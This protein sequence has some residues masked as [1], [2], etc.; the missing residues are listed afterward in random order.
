MLLFSFL[1]VVLSCQKDNNIDPIGAEIEPT[2]E[3]LLK[4]GFTMNNII[5][6]GKYYVVEGDMVFQ[7]KPS[8]NN[9]RAKLNQL[10]L[11]EGLFP[12][13]DLIDDIRVYVES[14]PNT[15]WENKVIDATNDAID[16][17]NSIP[18]CKINFVYT[19]NSN[20]A[21]ITVFYDSSLPSTTWAETSTPPGCYV[22]PEL[23]LNS[24]TEG[25]SADQLHFLLTHELGH[26]IGFM[27]TDGQQNDSPTFQIPETPTSDS[28]SVMNSGTGQSSPPSWSVDFPNGFSTGDEDGAN[29]LYPNTIFI[30]AKN[31][32]DGTSNTV[33][34]TWPPSFACAPNVI[35]TIRDGITVVKNSGSITHRG[36]H[37]FTAT[38]LQS[39][40][41]YK[42]T[43]S[44]ASNPSVKIERSNAIILF[45]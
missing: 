8:I 16:E 44:D 18:N 23:R 4:R 39:N 22:G 10:A 31:S 3:S 15:T 36:F 2:L 19:T 14:F 34:I 5:D 27:H 25:F 33:L 20:D 37:R 6:K 45:L 41:F 32:P 38:N 21:D 29:F 9:K 12:T 28:Q 40:H 7:K 43:V 11:D 42:L 1:L 30:S 24:S 35:V 13:L 17:W 26:S